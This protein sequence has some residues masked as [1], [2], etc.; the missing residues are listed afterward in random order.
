MYLNDNNNNN[1]NNN[2]N[3]SNK[4]NDYDENNTDAPWYPLGVQARYLSLWDLQ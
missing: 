2:S 3:N 1:N 4:N